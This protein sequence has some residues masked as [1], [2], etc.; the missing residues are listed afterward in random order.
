M[1]YPTGSP[2]GYSSQPTQQSAPVFGRPP[3]R[4]NPLGDLGLPRLMYLL[5]TVLSLVAYFCSFT[6]DASGLSIQVMILLAGGL[7]AALDLLPKGPD[8]LVFA[9]L[10]SSIGG[11]SVLAA[12]IEGSGGTVPTIDIIILV[13]ALLQLLVAV[14]A[15][16]LDH[17]IIKLAPRQAV[18][19]QPAANPAA[20]STFQ[21]AQQPG[22]QGHPGAQAGPGGQ[23]HPGQGGPGAQA[24]GQP[25]SPQPGQPGQPGH[26]GQYGQPPAQST[27]FMQQPGQ[28]GNPSSG[29]N[30]GQQ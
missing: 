10:L 20:T 26:P 27:Q 1:S 7:L 30:N 17:E 18:P 3:Q 22:P 4:P 5:V 9:T 14:A 28:L 6:S 11:L 24:P 21:P 25:G 13:F 12:V 29:F 16:L 2:G 15:L 8:T 19:Y 23:G